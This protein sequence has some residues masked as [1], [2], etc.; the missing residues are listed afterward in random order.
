V[1]AGQALLVVEA[2]K[3]RNHVTSGIPGRV[4]AVHTERG[5][6]VRREQILVEL[7]PNNA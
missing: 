5:H 2:M 4:R 3:V 7:E 6:Q 1:E